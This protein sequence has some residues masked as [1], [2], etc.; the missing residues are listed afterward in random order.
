MLQQD[1]LVRMIMQLIDG[2][3]QSYL[4]AKGDND[5]L[6]AAELLEVSLEGA[7]EIDSNLLLSLDPETMVGMLQLS[8]ID[9]TVVEYVSR[10]LLLS[11]VYYQQ[12][13]QAHIATLREHQAYALAGAY[14]IVLSPESI[15]ENNMEAFFERTV[16]SLE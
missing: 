9:E 4:R 7:T 16:S 10:S 2:I 15:E 12:A 14:D 1:Y 6:T 13:E 8:D 11:S 5:P 3:R